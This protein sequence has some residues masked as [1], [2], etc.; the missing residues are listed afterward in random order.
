MR[1][2]KNKRE[3]TKDNIIFNEYQFKNLKIILT[4]QVRSD[5]ERRKMDTQIPHIAHKTNC[6]CNSVKT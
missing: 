5:L 2:M 3:K 4:T 6:Y 1:E